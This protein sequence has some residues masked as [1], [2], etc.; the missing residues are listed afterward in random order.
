[1]GLAGLLLASV[2]MDSTAGIFVTGLVGVGLSV[3]DEGAERV[4][5]RASLTF[6]AILSLSTF[7]LISDPNWQ[8]YALLA[9]FLAVLWFVL[10]KS[11]G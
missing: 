5:A 4:L 6:L 1:M 2:A 9:G 7:A 11:T 3:R 10:S 8:S